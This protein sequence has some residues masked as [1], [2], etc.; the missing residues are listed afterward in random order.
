MKTKL[1]LFFNWGITYKDKYVLPECAGNPIKYAD[2]KV[3]IEAVLKKHPR[4]APINPNMPP[5]IEVI[6][7][8]DETD[9]RKTQK[10]RKH[11]IKISKEDNNVP[12]P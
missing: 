1:E 5:S 11:S 7:E 12:K 2:K 3:L 8:M 10:P 9:T 6:E 4:P